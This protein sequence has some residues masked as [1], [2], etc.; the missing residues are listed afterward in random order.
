M[1]S[2]LFAAERELGRLVQAQDDAPEMSGTILHESLSREALASLAI[3]GRLV[4]REDL[5]AAQI[6]HGLLAGERLRNVLPALDLIR[7]GEA[8][9]RGPP[10]ESPALNAAGPDHAAPCDTRTLIASIDAFLAGEAAAGAPR[11]D[12]VPTAGVL[13]P[14]GQAWMAALWAGAWGTRLPAGRLDEV[15]DIVRTTLGA[16]AGLAG[17]AQALHR[18]HA[19]DLWPEPA[20]PVVPSELRERDPRGSARLASRLAESREVGPGWGFAR[21]VFPWIVARACDLDRPGPWISAS[22]RARVADYAAAAAAPSAG[23]EDWLA[24]IV[25]EA[26]RAHRRRIG[27]ARRDLAMWRAALG[28]GRRPSRGGPIAALPLLVERPVV[29]PEWLAA[30]LGVSVR[31]AQ[32]T[33]AALAAA[34]VVRE[35]TGRYCC[36]VWMA[37]D[38]VGSPHQG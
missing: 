34:G 10:A 33:L 13:E 7:A 24:E 37:V 2:A 26:A 11:R 19:P 23:W 9:L 8:A 6:D 21:L 36:K 1:S 12:P 14:L 3:D 28:K 5:A 29:T 20:A 38:S 31:A 25:A 15:A 22:L 16:R 17:A 32:A 18:L 30:R 35:T 4:D 27:M